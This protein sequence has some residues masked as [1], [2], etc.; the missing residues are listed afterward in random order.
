MTS[1][2]TWMKKMRNKKELTEKEQAQLEMMLDCTN[3]A[4]DGKIAP[5]DCGP[6]HDSNCINFIQHK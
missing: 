3:K 6:E 2:D 1:Y 5:C 4:L